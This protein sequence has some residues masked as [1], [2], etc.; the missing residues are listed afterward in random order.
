MEFRFESIAVTVDGRIGH[1]QLNRPES[2]N[3]V[4]DVML[5]ELAAAARELDLIPGVDVVLLDGAGEAFCTGADVVNFENFLGRSTKADTNL[6]G[7]AERASALARLG[8]NALDA[9]EGMRAITISSVRGYAIGAG[10]LLAGSAD[11]RVFTSDAYIW[12]PE[13]DI[14]APLLWGGIPRLVREFGPARTK[15][16]IMT[17]RKIPSPEAL[18]LGFATQ[19]V[20]AE[21]LDRAIAELTDNLLGKAPWVL[22][23]TKEH[24]NAIA[25]VMAAGDTSFADV[26]IGTAS[27]LD[28]RVREVATDF[29]RSFRDRD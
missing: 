26:H 10:A 7:G 13:I 16:L 23:A 1:I 14:G 15:S 21:E 2:R 8:R 17:C 28:P 27:W 24:V 25:A 19:V 6:V 3:A 5:S 29:T 9:L 4:T 20:P 12:I 11:L 22:R 18:A